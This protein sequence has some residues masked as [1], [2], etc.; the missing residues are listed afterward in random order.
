MCVDQEEHAV[1]EGIDQ[2]AHVEVTYSHNLHESG[3][4][5]PSQVS[6][7]NLIDVRSKP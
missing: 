2:V 3:R 6:Q 5:K 4:L 7:N 1:L